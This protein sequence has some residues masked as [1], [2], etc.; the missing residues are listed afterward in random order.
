MS[1]VNRD[2]K[3]LLNCWAV[4]VAQLVERL[5]PNPHLFTVNCIEK[6]IKKKRPILKVIR[7]LLAV[8][9]ST[10]SKCANRLVIFTL[11]SIL[12]GHPLPSLMNIFGH[13]KL[14][15][16]DWTISALHSNTLHSQIAT[17]RSY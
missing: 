2:E 10:F 4:V 6:A 3:R 15:E 17:Q 11:E 14:K 5:L 9:K 16:L 13:L 1:S 12:V 7:F 8:T